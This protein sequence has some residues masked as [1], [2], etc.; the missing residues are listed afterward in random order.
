MED[1]PP[2]ALNTAKAEI[3]DCLEMALAG[4]REPLSSILVDFVRR[5]G[6]KVQAFT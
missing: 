4:S 3:M 1:F 2:E 6:G 5:I